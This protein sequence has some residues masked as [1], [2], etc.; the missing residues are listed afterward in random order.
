MRRRSVTLLELVVALTV[1]AVIAAI[2]YPVIRNAVKRSKETV[3]MNKLHQLHAAIALYRTEYGGDG[4][5]GR[6]EQMGLP[7]GIHTLY[8]MK[9]LTLQDLRCA[10]DPRSNAAPVAVYVVMWYVD[11]KF[12]S[13][14][15]KWEQYASE[16]RENSILLVDPNHGNP[17]VHPQAWRFKHRAIGLFLNGTIKSKEDYGDMTAPEFWT[18]VMR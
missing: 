4:V 3:C 5:Y 17:S 18:G 16:Q 9:R 10:G 15:T 12:D 2:A 1:V 8:Y 6:I 14:P 13:R 7:P 11:E